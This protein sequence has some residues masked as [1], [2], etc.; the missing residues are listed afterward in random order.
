MRTAATNPMTSGTLN[1]N[2]GNVRL[3]VGG[4]VPSVLS[5]PVFTSSGGAVNYSMASTVP[6]ASSAAGPSLSPSSAVASLIPSPL[7]LPSSEAISCSN[8]IRKW[9]QCG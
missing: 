6:P 7:Q 2:T 8:V 5:L 4:S 1:T 9:W 3:P